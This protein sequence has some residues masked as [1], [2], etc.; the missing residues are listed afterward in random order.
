MRRLWQL[1]TMFA[2][3][4]CCL[5]AR[6]AGVMLFHPA[7]SAKTTPA[8]GLRTAAA[9]ERLQ[10]VQTADGRGHILFV[11]GSIWRS[12]RDP[13]A[14]VG[15]I[16]LPDKWPDQTR[17]VAE[18]GRSGLEYRFDAVLKQGKPSFIAE[19]SQVGDDNL[20]TRIGQAG[21][22]V[23]TTIDSTWQQAALEAVQSQHSARAAAVLLSIPSNR[24]LAMAAKGGAPDENIA[25]KPQTPGSVF[26]LA[27]AAAALDAVQVTADTHFT[28]DGTLHLA[29]TRMHCWRSHG[30]LSVV[31]AIAQSCDVSFAQIGVLMGRQGLNQIAHRLRL[32][33]TGLQTI[34]GNPTAR[35]P[36]AGR[37]RHRR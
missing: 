2:L 17:S 28:C 25:V 30:N 12:A 27:V 16:G 36:V 33:A 35:P 13:D 26:K 6:L 11:N 15:R 7:D 32:N 22:D 31:N 5:F 20:F 21:V 24:I 1:W 23:R 10:L 29:G 9:R 8:G 37:R 19:D 4:C 14:V 18:E 3:A 34:D